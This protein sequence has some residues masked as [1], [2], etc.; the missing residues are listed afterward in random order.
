MLHCNKTT[1]LEDF[2][3]G[4]LVDSIHSDRLDNGEM[5]A[6]MDS[7]QVGFETLNASQLQFLSSQILACSLCMN[8]KGTMAAFLLV[9][10]S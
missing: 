5:G 1:T 10:F 7:D 8:S 4:I 2:I 9:K 6:S 3:R